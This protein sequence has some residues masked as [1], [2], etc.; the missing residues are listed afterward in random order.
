[1]DSFE[2]IDLGTYRGD[3]YF[4]TG[5]V[6]P[7]PSEGDDFNPDEDAEDYGVS[8]AR[9]TLPHESNRQIVRMDTLHGQPHMDRVY[10]PQDADEDRKLWLEEGYTYERMK[11]YLLT[12]WEYFV[13]RYIEYNE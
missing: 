12:H 5:V 7:E 11:Q 9:S 8:L 4:L 2:T 10:L 6:E 3:D 13:D 1:M